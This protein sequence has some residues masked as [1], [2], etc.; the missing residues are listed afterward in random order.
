MSGNATLKTIRPGDTTKSNPFTIIIVSNPALEAPW[1]SGTFIVDPITSNQAAFDACVR[2]IDDSLF[3]KLPSQRERFMNDPSIEP[4][5]RV[6]S[7]FVTGLPAEDANSLVAQDGVSNMLVARRSVFIPFLA[8]QELQ[9]ADVV[10]AVSKSQSHTRASAW[11]TSDDDF[12]PGTS[13]TLDGVTLSHR[14]FNLVPGTI[15]LHSTSTSLTAMHEFG[16]A[17]SSYT[18]GSVVDLYVDSREGFN[19]KRGRPIP[20]NFRV[21]QGSASVSDAARDGISYPVGW[22]S[23]HCELL[24]PATPALMDNYW[25]APSGV[26]EHCRHDKITREFLTDRL[27]AKISR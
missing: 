23:Y 10:Y 14:Y 4:K 11:F 5:I 7:L 1:N 17:L 3:G 21:Y 26:P 6:Q 18:N 12:R 9:I 25:V 16:H 13:F 2:Y 27:R 24:D 22:Q 20:P 15:A 19:N 8:G